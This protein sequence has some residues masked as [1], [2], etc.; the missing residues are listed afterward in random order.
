MIKK[1]AILSVCFLSFVLQCICSNIAF[2]EERI[3][4]TSYKSYPTSAENL[5]Y[6][7]ISGIY[8]NGFKVSEIQSKGGFIL[9]GNE[10]QTFLAQ[11]IARSK[12]SSDLKITPSDGNYTATQWI[13]D[14]IFQSVETLSQGSFSVI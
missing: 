12:D 7:T 14:K 1:S 2:A 3:T 5:Y 9:F 11:V 6:S 4:L 10:S 8:Y 13:I